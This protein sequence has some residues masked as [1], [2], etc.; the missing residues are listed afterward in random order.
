MAEREALRYLFYFGAPMEKVWE[1]FVGAEANRIIFGGAEL[2]V[3]LKPGGPMNWVGTGPDGV[4]TAFVRGEV[5]D[6][7][8]PRRLQ[9]SFSMGAPGDVSRVTVELV[10]ESEATKVS[11]IHDQFAEGDTA[12]G[13]CADGWPRIL[14]RLKTLLETG[15]T[16]KPH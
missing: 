3:E 10:A 5:L 9:Y 12:Y 11:V 7:E 15:K 2:E 14:S 4:R 13:Y 1:G 16:F 8:P 6:A